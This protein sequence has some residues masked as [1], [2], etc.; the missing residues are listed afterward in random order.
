MKIP[1]LLKIFTGFATT[2]LL[3]SP[4]LHEEDMEPDEVFIKL[5]GVPSQIESGTV[6]S[7][8]TAPITVTLETVSLHPKLLFTISDTS[9]VP[10]AL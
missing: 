3:P 10:A 2:D 1:G 6:K 7:T 9:K 4:K 8:D 5:T